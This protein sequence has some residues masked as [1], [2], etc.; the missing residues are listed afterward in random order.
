M[1]ARGFTLIEV[2]VALAIFAV[3]ITALV[4]AGAQRADNMGYLRARTL[5]AWIASDRITAL[6]L[7]PAWPD[8]GTQ[9]GETDMA[10]RTW[11]WRAAIQETPE[12]AVRRID[13]EVARSEGGPS[14]SSVTGFVG[15]PDDRGGR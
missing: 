5:A 6:Q 13:V 4:Q 7:A 2:L 15:S 12:D 10:G 3:A 14:V 8:V 9:E 1:R 11:Y